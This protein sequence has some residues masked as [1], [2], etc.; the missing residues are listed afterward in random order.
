[1]PDLSG[2]YVSWRSRRQ[3][4]VF[5]RD[6]QARTD[7][8]ALLQRCAYLVD[9][10]EKH[11]I[12]RK[13]LLQSTLPLVVRSFSSPV[14]IAILDLAISLNP[15]DC[16]PSSGKSG[17]AMLDTLVPVLSGIHLSE[18]E[19]LARI[20]ILHGLSGL[21]NMYDPARLWPAFAA[22]AALPIERFRSVADAIVDLSRSG[23]DPRPLARWTSESSGQ[24]GDDA[25][26]RILELAVRITAVK[27]DPQLLAPFLPPERSSLSVA[28]FQ[29]LLEALEQI[30]NMRPHQE[31]AAILSALGKAWSA[32]PSENLISV[33]DLTQRMLAAGH[34]PVV[35]VGQLPT[36]ATLKEPRLT[37]A[38]DLAARIVA[39][40]IDAGRL[41]RDGVSAAANSVGWP[42][43]LESIDTALRLAESKIDPLPLLQSGVP[44]ASQ[45]SDFVSTLR[46]MEQH[47]VRTAA[48]SPA[49]TPHRLHVLH[50]APE[51][52]TPA[53]IEDALRV[54]ERL[55][56]RIE[57][58]GGPPSTA[59]GLTELSRQA[60]ALTRDYYDFTVTFHPAVTHEEQD[61]YDS[62]YPS[63]RTV[64]DEPARL[65]LKPT[66]ERRA[67]ISL[68]LRSPA[69]IERLLG[70]RSWLWRN[71]AGSV[72]HE[73][74]LER[75]TA[76][77]GQLGTIVDRMMRSGILKP[78]ESIAAIYLVGSYPWRKHPGDIDLFVLVNGRRE[79]ARFTRASLEAKG[80]EALDSAVP[81]DL[82]VVGWELL[83]DAAQRA[84]AKPTAGLS[85]RYVL[86]YGSV[87]LAGRDLHDGLKISS[88]DLKSVQA[89][90]IENDRR[91]DWPELAGDS[92]SI[93]EKHAWRLYEAEAIRQFISD[94]KRVRP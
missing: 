16:H 7:A 22:V 75:S 4:H 10:A 71:L 62:Y 50:A 57:K 2:F 55:M 90:I 30:L 51:L 24:I 63:Y 92:K 31:I 44:H 8:T 54:F 84:D 61:G 56:D 83:L 76:V 49:L 36:L 20:S 19:L 53:E 21:R 13:S 89:E 67:E 12:L 66:G 93:E 87:L 34:N 64:E 39:A 73:Q 81:L 60:L 72:E 29:V 17:I 46:V 32:L 9:A 88:A 5:E 15:Q 23:V 18:E 26:R 43:Y 48:W 78:H 37:A 40:G 70:E 91:A 14:T 52:R 69:E 59:P 45:T 58:S 25:F 74:A 77:Q 82:E 38:L 68:A 85:R 28:E 6:V 42:E 33:L 27:L 3:W 41:L 11:A 47:L 94:R 65:E 1:M 79:V 35:V 86:L 80:F